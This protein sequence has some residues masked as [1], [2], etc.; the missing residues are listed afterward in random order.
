MTSR[1]LFTSDQHFCHEGIIKSCNR[2][3]ENAD[4]MDRAM[5]E[6]WNAVVHKGDIVWHIGDFAYTRD[7]KRVRAIFHKLN[8]QIHLIEGNHDDRLPEDLPFASRSQMKMIKVDGRKVFLCHYAMREWPGFWHG[9]IHLY[10]HSHGRMPG[11]RR[12]IDVGVD[13][14]GYYPQTIEQLEARMQLLPDLSFKYG[15]E[16]DRLVEDVAESH[17][18]SAK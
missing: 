7:P 1:T 12:T 17:S 3:F 6:A 8:G 11:A 14:V 10:G 13:N 4:E 16:P 9:G 15:S 18:F 5:I 2:P